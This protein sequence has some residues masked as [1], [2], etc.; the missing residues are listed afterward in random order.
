MNHRTARA[1]TWCSAAARIVV[2][3]RV[4]IVVVL[5]LLDARWRWIWRY[6]EGRTGG[7]R[8]RMLT[9]RRGG[10]DSWVVSCAGGIATDP[11][12]HGRRRWP[13]VVVVHQVRTGSAAGVVVLQLLL[14]GDRYATIAAADAGSSSTAN[15]VLCPLVGEAVVVASSLFEVA[16][17]LFLVF[18]ILVWR[19][20]HVPVAQRRFGC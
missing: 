6:R 13:G 5:L 10:A 16:H 7:R 1:A 18:R 14:V 15:V 4:G 20:C 11:A 17:N 2:V 3:E 8:A 12:R 9:E 19:T